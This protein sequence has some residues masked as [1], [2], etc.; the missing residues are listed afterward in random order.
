MP[1][2]CD[3]NTQFWCHFKWPVAASHKPKFNYFIYLHSFTPDP[4]LAYAHLWSAALFQARP[5]ITF[6]VFAY[7]FD[8]NWN[9]FNN[10]Y[11]IW[12]K[13]PRCRNQWII[14]ILI[15]ADKSA[16]I[17][18]ICCWY[19]RSKYGNVYRVLIAIE[20]DGTNGIWNYLKWIRKQI[21]NR[22]H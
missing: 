10:M 17:F 19:F 1:S 7:I 13:R 15:V 12:W 3:I 20:W 22:A 8:T 16:R 18:I 14:F 5:I 9:P 4:Q 2:P 21:V 6:I 11:L